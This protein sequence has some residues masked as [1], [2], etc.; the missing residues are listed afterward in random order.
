MKLAAGRRLGPYEILGPIGAGGMGEVYRARDTRLDRIIAVKVLPAALAVDEVYRQRFEREARAASALNH[1]HI[2]HVYD[3]GVDEGTHFI[4]MEYVEGQNLRELVAH[5]PLDVD[6]MVD[7]GQQM[8][9]ALEEAHSRGIVHRDIKSANA[10][11]SPNGQVKLLDFGLA[12]RTLESAAALSSRVE[13]EARTQAGLVVGTVP[14]MSPEQALGKEVDHRTDLFSLGV[15]LYELAVGR[16]PFVGDTATQTIDQIC[17]ASPEPLSKSRSDVPAELERVVRKCL[18]KE[19]DRRYATAR[20]LLVD[21]RNLQRDRASGTGPRT[22]PA[23]G[24]NRRVLLVGAVVLVA[25]VAVVAGALYG[26]ARRGAS[27]GSVAV[28]PFENATGDPSNDYLSDGISESLINKL[29]S[30][31]GLRVISRKSA[32][33]FK[34]QKLGPA[35]IGAKLG[36][37][38]LLLGSLAQR[39]SSLAITAELVSVRDD[40]Q[41]WGEKYARRADD[42][43]QIEGEIAATI[44][45][46]LRRQ[47][48]GEETERLAR[49]ATDDPEAYRL[50]LKARGFLVGNQQEMDKSIDLFQQAVAKAPEYALAHAGLAEAH[51]RQAF[52]RG[53]GREEPLKRAR[54]AVKRALELDP[55]LAEAHAALGLVR[56][57]FEWDWAGAEAEFRRAIE[58]NPGSR[59]G[60]EE[61][62]WFLTAVGRLDE[63][64]AHSQDAAR[65][66]PLS[67][68]PV[69][70]MAINFMIRGDLDQAAATFRRAI[71]IDPN[72]TWGY[73]KPRTLAMQEVPEAM[74]GRG[75]R[76]ED[77]GRRCAALPRWLVP[78]TRSA[79]SPPVPPEARQLHALS[80]ERYGPVDLRRH[81][82]QPRRIGR[83]AALLREGLGGPDAEHG[84]RVDRV[85]DQPPAR[86]QPAPRGD[87]APDELPRTE[88]VV[89]R[90][91]AL[92]RGLPSA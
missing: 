69:H 49:A 62:G 50:Y 59:V 12:R 40:T 74:A 41:L 51:T 47:L 15:V 81:P 76:A 37:D 43:L 18:E 87:R 73:V 10:V 72:W 16:L 46:T 60:Q 54:A 31:P 11:V 77:R 22:A 26:K 9:S 79:G 8:A 83:G 91:V 57:Y 90:A 67:V 63:G 30:L 29:S 5:G 25:A 70:D 39:G 84:L 64:L 13:T 52:L 1:P 82:R 85:P 38:A 7:L 2:A 89:G 78:P 19:R 45:R 6:R 32:F 75:R 80:E 4:A 65:L 20:D 55:D 53:S 71:D 33:A 35:E 68:G 58:L 14:Y 66:D 88:A 24:K 92:R 86:G 42:V 23:P 36:V 21:L 48:S 44:A 56:F 3:V 61:Y 34:G 28:L 17:H 27:I